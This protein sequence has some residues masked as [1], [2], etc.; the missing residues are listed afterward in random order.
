[1]RWGRDFGGGVQGLL[2]STE[3][4]DHPGLREVPSEGSTVLGGDGS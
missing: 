3:V 1:M 2:S 4:H